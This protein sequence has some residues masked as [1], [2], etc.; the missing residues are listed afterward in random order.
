M[1]ERQQN[2]DY[3]TIEDFLKRVS[4][5]EVNKR[6]VENLIKAGAM[7]GLDGNR[8]QMITVFPSIM[9][10]ISSDK[11]SSM[12][13]QM[14]LFDIASDD[15]KEEFEIK[16][17]DLEEYD[18]E[19]FLALEKEV[20]G[21]YISGHPLEKIYRTFKK[22]RDCRLSDDFMLDEETHK[23]T[24]A[25]GAMVIIGGMITDK[26]II[27]QKQPDHGFYHH[28]RPLGQ[29]GSDRLC[30]RIRK[31]PKSSGS[32]QQGPDQGTC[33]GR[34]KNAKLICTEMHGFDEV[35]K[36]LWIQFATKEEFEAKQQT[37]FD[38]IADMDGEDNIVVYVSAIKAMKRMPAN[39]NISIN[40]DAMEKI[41]QIFGRQNVKVAG[42]EC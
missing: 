3:K 37:L 14:T 10:R 40:E 17:P 5:K 32:G 2:G 13:G 16:M 39:W 15:I 42:K 19:E 25:D 21:V 38:A 20:L 11:K 29:C 27:Y 22:E 9:D 30:Q 18:K 41:S 24:V 36:E 8:H 34:G 31:I 4:G 1:A 7:D 23:A 26:T 12:A 6:A 35:R 28:R 33:P